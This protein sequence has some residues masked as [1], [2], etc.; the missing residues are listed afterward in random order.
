MHFC[1]A[2]PLSAQERRTWV[3]TAAYYRAEGRGFAP[4]H[5]TED[6]LAAEQELEL[7]IAQRF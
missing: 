2:H 7:H 1:V 6:W 4:G 5:E 3:E